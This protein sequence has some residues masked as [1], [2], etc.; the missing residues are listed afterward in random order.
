ML[1]DHLY[2]D[3]E[4]EHIPSGVW[5]VMY[6]DDTVG[7]KETLVL[8]YSLYKEDAEHYLHKI[9]LEDYNPMISHWLEYKV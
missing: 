4:S 2:K 7:F 5:C 3:K 6:H 9:G 1:A 8:A